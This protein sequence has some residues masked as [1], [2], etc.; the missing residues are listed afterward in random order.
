M[1]TIIAASSTQTRNLHHPVITLALIDSPAR[2][3]VIVCI[4]SCFPPSTS[5]TLNGLLRRV[6][7]LTSEDA[8]TPTVQ[9]QSGDLGVGGFSPGDYLAVLICSNAVVSMFSCDREV[10]GTTYLNTID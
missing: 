8:R 4:V 2:A 10:R 7:A 3:N 1:S 6:R 5:I 9:G